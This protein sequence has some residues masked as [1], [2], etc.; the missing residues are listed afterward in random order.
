MC[1]LQLCVFDDLS[2]GKNTKSNQLKQCT[3]EQQ[4]KIVDIPDSDK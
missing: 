4:Q 1:Y 3:K 2:E